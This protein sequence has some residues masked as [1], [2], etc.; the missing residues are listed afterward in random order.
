MK[1]RSIEQAL[2]ALKE[3]VRDSMQAAR[4]LDITGTVKE[5]FYKLKELLTYVPDPTG[6]ELLQQLDTLL[7]TNGMNYH[8][9]S[10]AGDC[11]CFT[12][13]GLAVLLNAGYE[14]VYVIIAG[15]T[16][17][18]P[19]HIWVQVRDDYNRILNF[20]LTQ[21]EFNSARFYPYFQRLKFNLQ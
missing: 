11:D 10:G 20:D 18:A 6:R 4:N 5:I 21:P 16:K 3:Q 19:V 13:A 17:A 9:Q 7:D 12:I 14:N 2:L 8:G 1:Y 15:H